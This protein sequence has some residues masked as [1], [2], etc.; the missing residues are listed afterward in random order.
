M[1]MRIDGLCVAVCGACKWQL[2]HMQLEK[3]ALHMSYAVTMD[4][5]TNGSPGP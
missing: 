3:A 1:V 5:P 4:E 2:G